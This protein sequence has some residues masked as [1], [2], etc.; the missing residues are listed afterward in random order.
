MDYLETGINQIDPRRD[1]SN[2]IRMRL[3]AIKYGEFMTAL[4]LEWETNSHMKDTPNRVAK[5]FINDLFSGLYSEPPE[6]RQFDNDGHY[7][8]MVFQGNIEVHSICSHHHLP[9]LGKAHI[10]YI[11]DANGKMIG[12]SKL[13]R[14]VEHFAR[15][16][17]V[18]ETLTMEIHRYIDDICEKN[19]GVMVM[20]ESKHLCASCRGVRH[21]ST[22]MTSF[23][24]GAFKD[25]DSTRAE[26]YEFV[27]RLK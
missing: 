4:G 19:H 1:I 23:P 15:R 21:D 8:G 27:S 25:N 12:L 18:Q 11:P 13:N 2:D 17:Q 5:S 10:A 7:S 6:I 20:I 22:M 9:F 26:F 3:A 14:V 24:S 16:P